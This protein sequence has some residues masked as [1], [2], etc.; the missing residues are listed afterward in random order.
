MTAPSELARQPASDIAERSDAQIYY[1]ALKTIARRY[2]TPAQILRA[3]SQ[4]GMTYEE[5][6]E[7]A[8]ENLQS[9]AEQAIRGKRRPRS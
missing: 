3:A 7:M 5:Y 6:L 4:S 1:D 2:M 9:A 8:Y